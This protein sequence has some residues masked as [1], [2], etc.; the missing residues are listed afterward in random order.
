MLANAS[1]STGPAGRRRGVTAGVPPLVHRLVGRLVTD[2]MDVNYARSSRPYVAAKAMLRGRV[3]L[4]NFL[5]A[6]LRD[7]DTLEFARRMNV[8]LDGNLHLNSLL[9]VTVE[10]TLRDGRSE[11]ERVEVMY[12]HP[13]QPMTCSAHLEKFQHPCAAAAKRWSGS[14]PQWRVSSHTWT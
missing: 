6:A 9:R 7:P 8:V 5:P 4:E 10:I 3:E 13:A 12:R 11:T 2:V 1:A 14:S